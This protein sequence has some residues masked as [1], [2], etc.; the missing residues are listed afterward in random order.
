M[1][2][3]L[4]YSMHGFEYNDPHR[5]FQETVEQIQLAE[6]L[7]FD[8]A[9]ITEHHVVETGYFPAPLITCAALATVTSRIRLGTGVLLLPLYDP[10]HVAEHTAMLDIVSNG[11]FILGLGYGYR[12]E[13]FD[14]FGISLDERA[15][16]LNEGIRAI[17]AL[18]TEDVTNFEGKYFNY[19]NVTQR[20][21]PLQKPHPPIWLASKAEGAVRQAARNSD[22]WFADPITPFSVLK[23]RL[24]AYKETLAEFGKPTSGF[25][26]PIFREAYVADTDEQAWEEAKEGVLFIYKE[27]LEWGHLLDED[28][29]P[30][31]PDTPDALDLVRQRFLIGSPETCIR[32][33]LK[34]KQELGCTNVVMRMK[35]P[36]ISQDKVMKSIRL[37]GEQVLPAIA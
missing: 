9:L 30:V 31:K 35:Y 18:W 19:D 27:Y 7:G 4:V 12:Q 11:R 10:L 37:W 26:F 6:A 1:K 24:A 2:S 14:A 21:L 16:R 5:T 15:G 25:D 33:A 20:P 32:Q 29:R 17:R 36:G 13:E 22:A 23:L 3:S 34:V 8:A 28:G